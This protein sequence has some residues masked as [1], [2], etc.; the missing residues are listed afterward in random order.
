MIETK[1]Q[2]L[3]QGITLYLTVIMIALILTISFSLTALFLAQVKF[4][5]D[6]GYSVPAFYAAETGIERALYYSSLGET[7]P[8]SETLDNTASYSVTYLSPGDSGCPATAT[9]Y[10]LKSISSYR[11]VRRGIRVS[12]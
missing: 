3:N 8:W 6:I 2:K 1:L 10:C 4:L 9:A 12:R 7:G 11:G 5:R